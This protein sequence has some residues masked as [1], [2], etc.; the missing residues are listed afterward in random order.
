MET[1]KL[2]IKSNKEFQTHGDRT[3]D[4]N[5]AEG[6]RR[7]LCVSLCLFDLARGRLAAGME[8]LL[9]EGTPSRVEANS[10][11]NQPQQTTL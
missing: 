11:Q 1:W 5:M 10:T 4:N 9:S 7:S 3:F 6:G 2:K 8:F